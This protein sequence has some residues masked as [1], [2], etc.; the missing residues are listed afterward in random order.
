MIYKTKKPARIS[1][2][3]FFCLQFSDHYNLKV[4]HINYMISSN[5]TSKINVALGPITLPAP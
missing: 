5:S 1:L 4:Q 3:G 2:A